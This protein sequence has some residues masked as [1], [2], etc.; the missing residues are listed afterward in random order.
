MHCCRVGPPLREVLDAI[1]TNTQL[2]ASMINPDEIKEQAQN[3]TMVARMA[4][5]LG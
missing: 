4:A 3:A 2:S 5:H 1:S